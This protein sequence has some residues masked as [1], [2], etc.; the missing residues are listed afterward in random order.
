M[1]AYLTLLVGEHC[2]HMMINRTLEH[3]QHTV[4][5]ISSLLIVNALYPKVTLGVPHFS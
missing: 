1:I 4:L 5:M 3:E 2:S